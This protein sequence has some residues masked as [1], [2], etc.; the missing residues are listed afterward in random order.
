MRPGYILLYLKHNQRTS[1][2][3]FIACKCCLISRDA[4]LRINVFGT[5]A[6]FFPKISHPQLFVD[7]DSSDTEEDHTGLKSQKQ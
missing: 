6:V 1:G 2:M 5:D 3:H 4:V 7:A